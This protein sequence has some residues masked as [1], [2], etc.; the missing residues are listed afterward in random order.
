[1][2][3]LL[4]YRMFFLRDE[5]A[6]FEDGLQTYLLSPLGRF[7]AWSAARRVRGLPG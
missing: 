4:D 3:R 7:E 1:M 2:E 5:V 6:G